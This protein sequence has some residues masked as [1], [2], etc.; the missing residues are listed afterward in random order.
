MKTKSKQTN[1]QQQKNLPVPVCSK[2]ATEAFPRNIIG[3]YHKHL[4]AKI[5][6]KEVWKIHSL[7][8]GSCSF[9]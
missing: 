9:A 8:L 2:L 5:I 7:T 4:G 3:Q 6:I 1:K